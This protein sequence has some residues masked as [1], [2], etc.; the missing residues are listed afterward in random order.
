MLKVTVRFDKKDEKKTLR[1]EG[2]ASDYPQVGKDYSFFIPKDNDRIVVDLGKVINIEPFGDMLLVQTESI[3]AEIWIIAGESEAGADVLPFVRKPD[4]LV[5]SNG[6][7][8]AARKGASR[9]AMLRFKALVRR[10]KSGNAPG[11]QKPN[12]KLVKYS[13]SLTC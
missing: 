8:R 4:S 1:L 9:G 5:A 3:V 7:V 13:R 2:Y 12:L 6:V 11:K 10:L